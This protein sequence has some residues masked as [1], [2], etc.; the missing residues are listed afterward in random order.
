MLKLND[1]PQTI[2]NAPPS[3]IAPGP[4][5]PVLPIRARENAGGSTAVS[6]LGAG[7]QALLNIAGGIA[8]FG[9]VLSG[10]PM[11]ERGRFRYAATASKI[12]THRA[13]AANWPQ[14]PS[15]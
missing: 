4:L 2:D 3:G 13:M 1:R 14:F 11:T 8:R 9:S 15:R 7:R 12:Q 10:P 6:V 5:A